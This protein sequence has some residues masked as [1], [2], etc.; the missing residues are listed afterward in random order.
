MIKSAPSIRV[1][2]VVRGG[3]LESVFSSEELDFEYIDADVYEADLDTV[4]SE[5]SKL[6]VEVM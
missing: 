3:L 5:Y 4:L 2:A 6:Q 1:R